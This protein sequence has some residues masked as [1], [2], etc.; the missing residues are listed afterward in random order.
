M[1]Q[2]KCMIQVIDGILYLRMIQG[3]SMIPGLMY[4]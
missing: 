2:V 1:I 4:A 3:L